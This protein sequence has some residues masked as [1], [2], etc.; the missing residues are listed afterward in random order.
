MPRCVSFY[1]L[2]FNIVGEEALEEGAKGR[3]RNCIVNECDLILSRYS[4]IG[5]NA[6]KLPKWLEPM[7][8]LLLGL[9]VVFVSAGK[10]QSCMGVDCKNEGAVAFLFGVLMV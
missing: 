1:S 7:I 10:L 9:V 6:Q 3:G 5:N 4:A 2:S 8:L